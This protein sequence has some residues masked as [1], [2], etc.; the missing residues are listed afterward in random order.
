[1]GR[2]SKARNMLWMP[3]AVALA[4]AC[5][6]QPVENAGPEL[7]A[8]ARMDVVAGDAQTAEVGS[9]LANP[10]VVRVSDALGRPV[11]NQIVNFRVTAGGGSVFAG[12]SITDAQ[13][14]AQE[15]WTLG[16]AEGQMA[17]RCG[18]PASSCAPIWQASGRR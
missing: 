16:A 14:R 11:R 18:L 7:A 8:L 4:V 9:Q 10:L 2:I 1:M 15:W 17:S 12:A 6:D 13:G 5:G 3:V